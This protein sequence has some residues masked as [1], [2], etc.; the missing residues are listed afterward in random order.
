MAYTKENNRDRYAALPF[1][2]ALSLKEE[3]FANMNFKPAKG[4]P[5]ATNTIS[6]ETD[7]FGTAKPKHGT[8]ASKQQNSRRKRTDSA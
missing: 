2:A 4:Y 1:R 3:L 5:E 6:H 8:G 7:R